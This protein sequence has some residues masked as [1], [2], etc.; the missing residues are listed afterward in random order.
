MTQKYTVLCQLW[1]ES[2]RGWGVRPDG[3]SLHLSENDRQDYINAYWERMPKSV[4]DEYERPGC[5]PYWAEVPEEVF[6]KVK[7]SQ[8]GIRCYDRNYPSKLQ[9]T[10][11]KLNIT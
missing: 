4:P 1:E 2:E 7:A 9:L 6:N 10:G 5:N 8:Y 3:Y 11:G